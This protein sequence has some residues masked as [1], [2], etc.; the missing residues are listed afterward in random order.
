MSLKGKRFDSFNCSPPDI[1][2]FVEEEDGV[3]E[4]REYRMEWA[5]REELGEG[6]GLE[7]EIYAN[8]A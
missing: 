1:E 7:R 5:G 8:N 3:W 2:K 4:A 6:G